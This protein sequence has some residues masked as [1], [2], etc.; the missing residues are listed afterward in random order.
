MD[1]GEIARLCG[2]EGG[3]LSKFTS[4][5]GID[6]TFTG[7]WLTTAVFEKAERSCTYFVMLDASFR[8]IAAEYIDDSTSSNNMALERLD[9]DSTAIYLATED[10]VIKATLSSK[11]NTLKKT[12][13]RKLD[14][15]GRTGTTPTLLDTPSGKKFVILV[16]AKAAVKSIL[17]GLIVTSREERPSILVGVRREDVVPEGESALVSARLP[18]WLTTVENSPAVFGHHVVVSNYSGYLPR[19]GLIVP[20][21][22]K[23]SEGG[24]GTWLVSPDAKA[25]F[26]TGIVALLFDESTGK[27]KIAWEDPDVQFNGVP[28]ISGGANR[29]YGTGAE[30][31]RASAMFTGIASSPTRQVRRASG[32]SGRSLGK[33]P[34]RKPEA[35]RRG[36]MVFKRSDYQTRRGEFYDAGNNIV[37]LRRMDR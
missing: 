29:V 4:F 13:E 22:G 18:D 8:P 36:N 31:S 27:F 19:N 11:R 6:P 32:F 14:I 2:V 20:A 26:A 34:F 5:I 3:E 17:N 28:A 1:T 12:W 23:V 37:I 10:A 16:E 24:P 9:D 7:E 30:E 35:D 21:G 25:D 33:A 15:R